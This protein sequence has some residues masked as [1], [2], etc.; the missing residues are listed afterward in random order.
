MLRLSCKFLLH[1]PGLI[2][3]VDRSWLMDLSRYRIMAG[4]DL[5]PF[6]LTSHQVMQFTAHTIRRHGELL[7]LEVTAMTF[8]P[9]YRRLITAAK[10][11]VVR[12]W[13]FNNGALLRELPRSDHQVVTAVLC[14]G[15]RILTAGWDR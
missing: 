15:H 6:Y 8:D 11:G 2:C 9:T 1:D 12:V 14:A 3:P 10:N 7:D 4:Y 5:I 13:N